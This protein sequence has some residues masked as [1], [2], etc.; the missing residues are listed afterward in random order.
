MNRTLPTLLWREELSLKKL[1]RI[2]ILKI[3][4]VR[5]ILKYSYW[6]GVHLFAVI[7]IIFVGVFLA[8]KFKITDVSGKVDSISSEFAQNAIDNK[9]LGAQGT[10][11]ATAS[12]EV[13]VIASQISQLNKRKE[14]KIN[15]LCNL[16]ELSYVAPKNV[17]K[18]LEVKKLNNSDFIE[19]Q[20]IF[21]VKTHIADKT[22]LE[23]KV[24][25]CSNNFD[26]NKISEDIIAQ[27]VANTN[28]GDIFEWPDKKEWSDVKDS[29]V[30]DKDRINRAAAV[31]KIEPRLIVSSLMVEQLRL[32]YSQRELYKKYFEPLKILANSYKISLGVMAIK[33]ETAIQ[34]EN[35]LKDRSSVYYLGPEYENIFN[36]QDGV[37]Q[38]KERFN[39]LSSND[40]Y[41]NYLYGAIYLK[42]M[43][44]QWSRAGYDLT[45]RPEIVGT[46]F[47]VGFGQSKPN[48]NP[49]VGGSTVKIDQTEYSFG[50]L[51]NEFYYSAELINDFPFVNNLN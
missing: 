51:S 2:G 12:G 35:H 11:V 40:H 15:L 1:A 50:R 20:M 16:D 8:I 46:L 7:G 3:V 41:W 5:R 14:Q 48:A 38:A 18:I 25:T 32:F 27:R 24:S 45:V 31:A 36:Y 22:D 23:N 34:I 33:E 13:S 21:T 43:M 6:T 42:Q 28:S 30:K 49:K 4:K 39:R 26:A 47:N 9:I 10:S 29:I 37:D 44:T 17:A 19:G